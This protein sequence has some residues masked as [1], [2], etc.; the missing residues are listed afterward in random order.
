MTTKCQKAAWVRIALRFVGKNFKHFTFTVGEEC[1]KGLDCEAGWV[2]SLFPF[3]GLRVHH[4]T[5]L[6]EWPGCVAS[7]RQLKRSWKWYWWA[8]SQM[9]A[10]PTELLP[11]HLGNSIPQLV[12]LKIKTNWKNHF[13]SRFPLRTSSRVQSVHRPLFGTLRSQDSTRSQECRSTLIRITKW[14]FSC[15]GQENY[16]LFN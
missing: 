15:N 8:C 1:R 13:S 6:S 10:K 5:D 7:K 2:L 14:K 12:H 4:L 16:C 3:G 9:S 11:C